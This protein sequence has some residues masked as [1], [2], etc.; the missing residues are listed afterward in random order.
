[1]KHFP[2]FDE[3]HKLNGK[4]YALFATLPFWLPLWLLYCL[5]YGS[6]DG[7]PISWAGDDCGEYD[8]PERVDLLPSEENAVLE[9][10]MLDEEHNIAVM[11]YVYEPD[12]KAVVKIAG[13]DG[14]S[15]KTWKKAVR[16]ERGKTPPYKITA[17]ITMNGRKYT[18]KTAAGK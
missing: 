13:P 1:M 10:I 3:L 11:D 18:L 7:T 5:W 12:L 14:L 16:F 17:I 9:H 2:K 4:Q 15:E 8:E 6:E